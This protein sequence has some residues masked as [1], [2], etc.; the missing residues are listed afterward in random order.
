M[1]HAPRSRRPRRVTPWLATM[2]ALTAATSVHAQAPRDDLLVSAGWLAEH[3]DDPDL[4]LLHVGPEEA[5]AAEHIPGGRHVDLG[6][7]SVPEDHDAGT[8][9]SLEMPEPEVVAA[10]LERLGIGDDSRVV[11]YYGT[12]WVSASTRVLFTLDWIGL[13]ARSS[14]LDGGMRAWMEAGNP[15]TAATPPSPP[16]RRLTPRVRSDL[17]VSADWVHAHLDDEGARL[18]DARAPVHY[19]GIQATRLHREPVRKGHIP[20]AVNIPFN[21]L[22]DD[23]LRLRPAHELR[24]IFRAAGVEPG[25]TVVGYCHLG[26]F[27]T[28]MLFGARTLGHTVRLYDGS[29]QEW[30]SRA[31][32]P[33]DGPGAER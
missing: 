6:D 8:G 11:V 3:L 18:V 10:A 19:D 15:T 2:V 31:D 1:R 16:A 33:V 20:G 29:F 4:V 32:L 27:A 21:T 13:G 22:F 23:E 28:A 14:L 9:L 12:D 17:I 30:G 7:L 25:D 26:Q 5:Y 24:A